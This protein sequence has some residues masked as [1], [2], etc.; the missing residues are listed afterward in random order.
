MVVIS[1]ARVNPQIVIASTLGVILQIA[2]TILAWGDWNSF[3]D[4]PAR[5]ALIIGSVLLT[6]VAWFSG[7]SGISSGKSHSP[8]SKRIIFLFMAVIIAMILVAPYSDRHNLWTIGGDGMRYLGLA[9]FGMGSIIRLA[10]VF[11]LG[12]RG[13]MENRQ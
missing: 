7:T 1:M 6:I 5:T 3:F 13:K 8:A 9:L 2:L 11:A 10:A 12:R 4:H